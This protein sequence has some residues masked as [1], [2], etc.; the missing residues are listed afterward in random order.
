MGFQGA[1]QFGFLIGE[2]NLPG[3]LSSLT[4]CLF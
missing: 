3:L 4:L 1:L 2:L